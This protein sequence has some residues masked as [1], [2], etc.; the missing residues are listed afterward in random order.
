ALAWPELYFQNVGWVRF[1]PTPAA[2]TGAPPQW[3]QLNAA[4]AGPQVGNTT[5]SAGG[6]GATATDG[7]GS[8]IRSLQDAE[9]RANSGAVA[10]PI[11]PLAPAGRTW[12]QW[13]RV[14]AVVLLLLAA[15][16]L[17]PVTA[18]L[19]RRRRRRAAVTDAAR[20]EAAWADLHEQ[21]ADLGIALAGSLTP[22]QVDRHLAEQVALGDQPRAA[23]TRVTSAVERARYARPDASFGSAAGT[24]LA[25][26][27]E[28]SA[29]VDHDV[30]VVVRAVAGSRTRGQR[31]RAALY[32]RSGAARTAVVAQ[33]FSR[34]ASAVDA[35]LAR[36]SHRVRMPRLHRRR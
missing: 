7:P 8:R 32:P 4:G 21:V 29:D 20:A 36:W 17:T 19:G 14:G 25:D 15:I 22:R 23:L 26:R 5:A 24:A 11:A 18:L 3:A 9:R 1:E 27:R 35:T 10:E 12:S 33:W 6:P 16:A 13:W 34:G 30:R 2:R 28:G 31:L